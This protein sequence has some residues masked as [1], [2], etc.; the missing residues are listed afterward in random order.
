MRFSSESDRIWDLYI[1]IVEES[2][3]KNCG[4]KCCGKCPSVKENAHAHASTTKVEDDKQKS[5]EQK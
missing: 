3:E 5:E 4:D 2:N 1:G